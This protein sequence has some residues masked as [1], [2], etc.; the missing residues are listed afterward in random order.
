MAQSETDR[1]QTR[2]KRQRT[3]IACGV[4]QGKTDLHRIVRDSSGKVS[5]DEAGRSAGRGAYVCSFDCLQKAQKTHKLDHAL[6]T[7]ISDDDYERI[8]EQMQ[9]ALRNRMDR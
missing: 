3:C 8:A 4:Q 7:K 5:F 9:Q 1:S 6:K 2:V